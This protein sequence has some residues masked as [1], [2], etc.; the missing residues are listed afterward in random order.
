MPANDV[1]EV[2]I[3][4]TQQ[5]QQ[6]ITTHHFR[7]VLDDA[8]LVGGPDAPAALVSQWQ[9]HCRDEWLACQDNGSGL[10][11]QYTLDDLLVTQVVPHGVVAPASRSFPDGSPGTRNDPGADT[12][13]PWIVAHVTQTTA[14]GGRSYRGRF[15]VS[16]LEEADISGDE[17]LVGAGL[18]LTLL[19]AYVSSLEAFMASGVA[20]TDWQM[21]VFSRRLC[22]YPAPLRKNGQPAPVIAPPASAAACAHA[23][24]GQLIRPRVSSLRSRRSR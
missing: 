12:L 15:F 11:S 21:V 19:N 1:Y 2:A 4:G 17:L 3:R 18:F 22:G 24:T 14:L 13:A 10:S 7:Q 16:G 8:S 9:T 5:G 6:W 23:V 20:S